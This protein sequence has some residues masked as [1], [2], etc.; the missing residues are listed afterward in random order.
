M[1][2]VY[3]NVREIYASFGI[4]TDRVIEGPDLHKADTHVKPRWRSYGQILYAAARARHVSC[5]R[6]ALRLP[7]V[8]S[9]LRASQ[10]PRI[11]VGALHLGR[12]NMI[13]PDKERIT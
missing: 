9:P 6:V 3:E 4:D 2:N 5:T 13:R 7:L 11:K 1:S 8:V 10:D 12:L